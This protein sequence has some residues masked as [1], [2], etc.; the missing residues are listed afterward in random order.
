MEKKKMTIEAFYFIMFLSA[1]IMVSLIL[2]FL[3]SKYEWDMCEAIPFWPMVLMGAIV[4]VA[5]W[6]I[7]FPFLLASHLGE[8]SRKQ[9]PRKKSE[10]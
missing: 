9:K 10:I 5:I 2:T 3:N 8:K 7:F 6:L 4:Q 1:W